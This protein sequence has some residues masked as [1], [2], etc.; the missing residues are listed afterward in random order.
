M[1]LAVT[2]WFGCDT[3]TASTH[4]VVKTERILLLKHLY[5]IL[6]TAFVLAATAEMLFNWIW[7]SEIQLLCFCPITKSVGGKK[8]KTTQTL[9]CCGYSWVVTAQVPFFAQSCSRTLTSVQINS[10]GIKSNT[11]HLPPLKNISKT[12][13]AFMISLISRKYNLINGWDTHNP[14][15]ISHMAAGIS[16]QILYWLSNFHI[17]FCSVL[18][19]GEDSQMSAETWGYVQM[20]SVMQVVDTSLQGK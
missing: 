13:L 12:V 18:P 19:G 6:V 16:I 9:L 14:L 20:I 2:V 3:C 4:Q 10:K 1:W 8:G 11:S 5:Q 7:V 15:W 17:H